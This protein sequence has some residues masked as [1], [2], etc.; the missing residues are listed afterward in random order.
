M[1]PPNAN[2]FRNLARWLLALSAIGLVW[3]A[4]GRAATA[5]VPVVIRAAL[6]NTAFVRI[7]ENDA[8][9]ALTLLTRDIGRKYGYETQIEVSLFES[10]SQLAELVGHGRVQIVFCSAWDFVALGAEDTLEARFLTVIAGQGQHAALLLARN[11]RPIARLDDLRGGRVLL[12]QSSTFP[13]GRPWIEVSL[14]EGR[15]GSLARFFGSCQTVDKPSAAVIPVFFGQADACVVDDSAF[16]TMIEMN[17]AI[18]RALLPIARS[19]PL[20][21]PIVVFARNGWEPAALRDD[22]AR[23]MAELQNDISGRQVLALFKCDRLRDLDPASL[24][25]IRALY[26][27]RKLLQESPGT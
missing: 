27:R 2:R 4:P 5:R 24:Q 19:V 1:S 7:N 8:R 16:A 21:N 10:V 13:L 18:G 9:A 6:P 12:L 22:V 15:L 25:T 23:G 17:P 20:A 14:L 26:M 11:D 3:P